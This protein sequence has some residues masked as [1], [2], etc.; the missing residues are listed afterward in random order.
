MDFIAAAEKSL[1]VVAK[2]NYLDMQPG[3]VPVTFASADLLER[4]TGF[5][6]AT[7]IQTGVDAFVA[8]YRAHYWG[9][10]GRD[11]N[12]RIAISTVAI[13]PPSWPIDLPL[14]RR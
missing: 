8:W 4:L 7:P 11:G 13:M 10:S 9:V 1:G 12:S 5:K 3:D 14:R 2:R 6:P